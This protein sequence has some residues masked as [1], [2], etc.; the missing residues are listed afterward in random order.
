MKEVAVR[1]TLFLLHLRGFL[2]LE[3]KLVALED[4]LH[5]QFL[6]LL[7]PFP[8]TVTAETLQQTL[9]VVLTYLTFFQVQ[10]Q[11]EN[12]VR[13]EILQ[14][15]VLVNGALANILKEFTGELVVAFATD[16]QGKELAQPK[17]GLN[18]GSEHTDL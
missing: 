1:Q 9:H 12:T 15:E 8:V 17:G 3:Q 2:K 18:A 11:P 14:Q 4:G 16:A 5:H 13:R 10:Q 7:V 6:M